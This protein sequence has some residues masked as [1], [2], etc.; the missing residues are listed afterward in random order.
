MK[1]ITLAIFMALILTF[2]FGVND[3]QAGSINGK[4]TKIRAYDTGRSI[5]FKSI[6]PNVAIITT[7]KD[8]I[9][10][11]L[12]PGVTRTLVKVER[13]GIFIDSG[14]YMGATLDRVGDG[15]YIKTSVVKMFISERELDDVRRMR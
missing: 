12:K 4:L 13:D 2:T 14:R 11:M 7:K 1:K 10:G 15:L 3:A 8:I 5:K 9:K 6:I